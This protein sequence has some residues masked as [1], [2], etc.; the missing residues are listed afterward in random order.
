MNRK[1][2]LLTMLAGVVPWVTLARAAP[3]EEQPVPLR[4]LPP[5]TVEELQKQV[6]ELTRRLQEV[7]AVQAR[8]VGFT[9]LPNG[10]LDLVQP[11]T[12]KVRLRTG[13]LNLEIMSDF[14]LRAASTA[15]LEAGSSLNLKSQAAVTVNAGSTL[16]LKGGAKIEQTA[17]MITLN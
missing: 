12:S 9:K 13:Q 3:R 10:D 7:E 6:A 1:Q 8:T 2:A 11:N 17:A 15:T 5:P 16:A 4:P 14:N